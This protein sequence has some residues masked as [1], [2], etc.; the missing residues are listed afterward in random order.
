MVAYGKKKYFSA[1]KLE[2]ALEISRSNQTF[3]EGIL[4]S[5]NLMSYTQMRL[6][7]NKKRRKQSEDVC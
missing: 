6:W 4:S 2:M 7:L 5:E 1:L 3:T